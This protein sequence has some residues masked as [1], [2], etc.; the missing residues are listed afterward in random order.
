M[1]MLNPDVYYAISN[2]ITLLVSSHQTQNLA[3]EV[4][5]RLDALVNRYSIGGLL[6]EALLVDL[7]SRV[8]VSYGQLKSVGVGKC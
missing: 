8:E 1:P 5:R 7:L 2:L 4:D 6:L 3:G